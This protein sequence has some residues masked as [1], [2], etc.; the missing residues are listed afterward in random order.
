MFARRFV[1][2]LRRGFSAVFVVALIAGDASSRQEVAV[3]DATPRARL[4]QVQAVPNDPLF[5]KQWGLQNI[6]TTPDFFQAIAG[7]DISATRAWDIT[8]GD[9]SVIVAVVDTGID[10]AHPDLLPNLWID[11]AT[12]AYGRNFL[13]RLDLNGQDVINPGEVDDINGHGTAMASILGARGNNQIGISGVAWNGQIMALRAFDENGNIALTSGLS[14]HVSE[15]IDFAINHGARIINLSFG[16]IDGADPNCPGCLTNSPEYR[17]LERAR[18]AG[19]LVVAA[20]C[21]EGQDNDPGGGRCFPASFD[22]D[23]IIAVAT[24]DFQY[25]IATFS[26]YGRINVVLAAPGDRVLGRVSRWRT[27]KRCATTN[28]VPLA[29]CGA[30]DT[31]TSPV[32][33]AL[34][35]VTASGSALKSGNVK[36]ADDSSGPTSAWKL[37]RKVSFLPS[38]LTGPTEV[39][40]D[41]KALSQH[42][43]A[44]Q[45]LFEW[46]SQAVTTDSIEIQCRVEG[47]SG[48]PG[49]FSG[50]SA[51]AAFVSGAA[52]LLLAKDPKQDYHSLRDRIL[53]GVDPLPLVSDAVRVASGGR[54]SVVG[55]LGLP[56]SPPVAQSTAQPASGGGGAMGFVLLLPWLRWIMAHKKH[57]SGPQ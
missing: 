16:T 38:S 28:G 1:Q 14:N 19:I 9:P 40:V 52:A 22:L 51:A 29:T 21:N 15:A 3:F 11:P 17:A 57:L 56:A 44:Y 54:L 41:L 30:I 35:S 24:S 7:A 10:T 36:W 25:H 12:R 50:T 55:A 31:G 37:L 49:L 45:L 43:N 39:Y 32:C 20:A 5:G 47:D 13:S 48:S 53:F 27:L 4:L 18:N 46:A 26:N 42:G 23:N 6:G 33:R 8:T 34:L 2:P